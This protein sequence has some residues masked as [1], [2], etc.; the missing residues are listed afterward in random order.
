MAIAVEGGN[1]WLHGAA[2]VVDLGS[3]ATS[4]ALAG[5]LA[6][7]NM[8]RLAIE[9]VCLGVLQLAERS[10]GARGLLRPHPVERIVRDLTLY[11]RQPAPDAALNQV[12]QHVLESDAPAHTLW[13]NASA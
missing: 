6:Y 12:G 10:V 7:A 3:D 4:D 9:R 8:T 5:V 1:L 2:R 13:D 11:L